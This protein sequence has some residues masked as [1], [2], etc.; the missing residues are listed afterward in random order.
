MGNQDILSRLFTCD[1]QISICVVKQDKIIEKKL[2]KSTKKIHLETILI[3][4]LAVS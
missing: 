1:S 3:V 2:L 4:Y